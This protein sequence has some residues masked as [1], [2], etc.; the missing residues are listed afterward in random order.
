VIQVLLLLLRVGKSTKT[1]LSPNFVLQG[2]PSATQMK[3]L[4]KL[5][6]DSEREAK[7]QCTPALQLVVHDKCNLGDF[8]LKR[9]P[10]TSTGS[11]AKLQRDPKYCNDPD[12]QE[13]IQLWKQKPKQKGVS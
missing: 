4:T 9:L 10:R 12:I 6:H 3:Q 13:V 8:F 1:C 11:V 7:D 2:D 5:I